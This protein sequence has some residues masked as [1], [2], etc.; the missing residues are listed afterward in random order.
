M[1]SLE[2][3][4]LLALFISPGAAHSSLIRPKPRNAIDSELPEW[5][6]GKAPY[7]W[8]PHGN[9]PCACRNGT[10]VCDAAQTCLWMSVGC[11]IGCKECDGGSKGGANPNGKDRCG[12]GM[13]ATIN[14]PKYRTLN[15][16]VTAGSAEDWT[17]FNPWRA[18]GNAPVFDPCGRA[19]GASH[20]TPG[21]GEFTNTTFAKF[22]DLG[23]KVLPKYPTGTVWAAGST[24]ETMQS[25]RANHGGGYQYRLCPLN[26]ELTEACFQQTPMPFADDSSLMLSNGTMI[27]LTSTFVSEGTLPVGST[28]QMLAIPDTNHVR[29]GVGPAEAWAFAPPCFEPRY[30]DQPLGS[31]SEG[32]CSGQWMNNITIFDE[33]RVPE[34]LEPGEYVLGLRWDCETSAQIW[35]SCADVTITAPKKA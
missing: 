13:N 34:S 22:G 11:T 8:E 10:D 9:V 29:P 12:S 30:P 7:V 25:I 4:L 1:S 23:S 26:S 2:P 16:N 18:P 14:D 27:K 15:R 31:L 32:R 19:G 33:L 3:C 5:H 6:G 21:H 20:P 35:Q 24:V 28:W 17:R